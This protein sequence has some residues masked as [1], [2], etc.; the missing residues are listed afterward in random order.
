MRL[1][2]NLMLIL[3]FVALPSQAITAKRYLF[4]ENKDIQ[5][6]AYRIRLDKD[7]KNG[8]RGRIINNEKDNIAYL[9]M[10]LD[11]YCQDYKES[12]Q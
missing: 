1:I 5:L 9:E 4:C 8:V 3:V 10:I 11:R 12:F 7:L 6:Q 2:I